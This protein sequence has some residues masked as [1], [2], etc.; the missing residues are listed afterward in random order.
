MVSLDAQGTVAEV[1]TRVR[2]AFQ[3]HIDLSKVQTIDQS[4]R[5]AQNLSESGI[6]WLT[7]AGGGEGK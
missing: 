1:Q 3:Q 4:D 5:L 6:D 2:D 7:Y